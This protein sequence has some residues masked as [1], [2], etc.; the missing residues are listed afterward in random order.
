MKLKLFLTIS[1]LFF[2]PFFSNATVEY[3]E[4][5]TSTTESYK[6]KKHSKIAKFKRKVKRHLKTQSELLLPLIVIIINSP[7]KK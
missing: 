6:R 4:V 3:H 1:I 7:Y 2:V 5:K